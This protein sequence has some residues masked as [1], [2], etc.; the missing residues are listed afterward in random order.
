MEPTKVKRWGNSLA[1]R[2]PR[3]L[4]REIGVRE[5]S[6]ILLRV[7]SGA[8]VI[9]RV[10]TDEVPTLAELV[11]GITEENRHPEVD[12]GPDVGREVVEW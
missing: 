11:A 10:C 4:A 3:S 7:E 8:I 1:V 9:E 6:A 12:W 5:E 2:I